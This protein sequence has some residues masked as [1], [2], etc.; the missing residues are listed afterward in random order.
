MVC[1]FI[2][3]TGDTWNYTYCN[4]L[5]LH[6]ARP[7]LLSVLSFGLA[8][9]SVTGLLP[10]MGWADLTTAAVLGMLI[11]VLT[12]YS[13]TRPRWRDA[14]EAV[15]A[16]SSDEHTSELQS[17]MRISYAVFCLKNKTQSNKQL[18]HHVYKHSN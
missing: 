8:A 4:T 3:Y 10:R 18:T 5:S 14:H 11:G 13:A 16:F 12:E 15:A 6:D 7:D 9:A 17:L 2:N 1:V